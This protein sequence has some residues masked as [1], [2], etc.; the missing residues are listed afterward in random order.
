VVEN[1][2]EQARAFIAVELPEG[3]RHALAC[4]QEKLKRACGYCP[5]RW[6]APESIHLTL[7]FLGDVPVAKLDDI[8]SA[9]AQVA[10]GAGAF[11]LTLGGLGAFPNLE[12]PHV[13]W[14]GLGGN[15]ERLAG[16]QRN[17]KQRLSELG[18]SP[19]NQPFSPHLTLARVRDEASASDKKRLSQAIASTACETH[20]DIPV[21]AISLIKSQLTPSGPVYTVLYSSSLE[22]QS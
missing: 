8:K 18:F 19:E 7:N 17:L 5:A 12:R 16:I 1:N 13:I 21:R 2:A 9:I 4:L 15:V 14:V 20:C 22:H 3:M 6:V 10:S 11:E